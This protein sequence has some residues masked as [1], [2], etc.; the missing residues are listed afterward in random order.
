MYKNKS[1][2]ITG[3][4]GSFGKA[5]IKKL[6]N[7]R[8]QFRRI[9]I[10]SRDE[11]KQHEMKVSEN[12]N[13]RKHKNLRYFIGDV[14]DK[15]RLM[16]ALR[17]VDFVIHAAALKQVD[18]SEYN[19]F[20]TIKTNILGAQN[21]IEAS[22]ENNVSKVISL[23]AKKVSFSNVDPL[24]SKNLKTA[25]PGSTPTYKTYLYD[26][27]CVVILKFSFKKVL[28]SKFLSISTSIPCSPKSISM[29]DPRPFSFSLSSNL[30]IASFSIS[31][32]SNIPPPKKRG[33]EVLVLI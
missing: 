10:F 31:G 13:T 33:I 8:V 30:F 11:L 17:G 7:Q 16:Y 23:S 5:Y 1:I 26:L 12:F 2:L 20:E 25:L 24:L 19:P 6:L 18:T 32:T 27:S 4:T 3:A 15:D 22:L 14:R 29:N 9:I 21:I 28:A